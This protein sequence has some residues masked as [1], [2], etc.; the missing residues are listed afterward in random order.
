LCTNTEKVVL[1]HLAREGTVNPNNWD[2]V[3]MLAT[4]G[5]L[6]YEDGR[7][8]LPSRSFRR[9]LLQAMRPRDLVRL[10]QQQLSVWQ[11]VSMP[12][13]ALLLISVGFFLWS[14]PGITEPVM[15]VL[16]AGAAGVAALVRLLGGV[17]ATSERARDLLG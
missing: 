14:Q 10:E 16:G 7:V 11:Q 17:G 5:L 12:L 6:R 4:R 1:V 15:A 9:F 3:H 2:I 8:A 13:F